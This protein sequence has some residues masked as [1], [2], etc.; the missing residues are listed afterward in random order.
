[1]RIV[2]ATALV[3][4]L[5]A[6]VVVL[7]AWR[8][9]S[10]DG[11]SPQRPSPKESP[12]PA[13]GGPGVPAA[14]GVAGADTSQP[15][16]DVRVETFCS[17]CHA[18]P[19]PDVEPKR[20]WPAKIEQMYGYASKE[21]PVPQDRIPPIDLPID[22]W[23]ARAPEELA[24]PAD[25]LGSP[26]SPLAFACRRIVLE[27]I[28]APPSVSSVRFVRLADDAPVQLLITDM[29]HGVVVLW[30]P[31][32]R[33]E[34]AVVLAR[35]LHPCRTHV[36]DLDGDG[37]RDI[38]V[39]DLGD[40]WP[41]DTD[42]GAV[43][44]LRNRGGG[45]FEKI[46]LLDH[47][48]RVADAQA[49]DFDGDGDLDLL[50]AVFGNLTTG[51][52]LYLENCTTDWSRPE[53]EAMALDSRTGATETPILD[54]NG[55]GHPDFLVLQSQER[56]QVL[57][58]VNR[59][60]GSF[61]EETLF[62]ATHPRWGS[63]GIKLV[64]LNGDGRVDVLWNHGDSVEVPPLP[65]P[66]HGISW[67]ENRG[68]FPFTYHRL[69]HMPGAHTS[70]PADLDGDGL[71]D[72]VASAFIP[73]FNPQWPGAEKLDS[74]A[75]VRQTSPGQFRRFAIETATPFHPCG[76]VGDIDGDR[77]IDIVLGNFSMVPLGSY[78][79]EDCLVVLTNGLR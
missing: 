32:R 24:L 52:L 51:M 19:P 8:L 35:M 12:T 2:V 55:D 26:P 50:V 38:L 70:I 58:F 56:D 20:L 36:V 79:C 34:S 17:T 61:Q 5:V 11:R 14:A 75:W 30:T 63:T 9:W 77:D 27:A 33:S 23:T 40:Y 72:V 16:R 10:A 65:R 76:D 74:I 37:L 3:S 64:D 57:A 42:Q 46:V 7:A 31:S 15:A 39:A 18:L 28:P 4:A 13:P 45:Q 47:Q 21:R 53:F 69:A 29:R 41:V 66:Y 54:L 62:K 67:L 71:V 60:W 59:G 78:T 43:V 1:M 44:W 25:A 68:S 49:A 73:A 48:G 6:V 22:Y